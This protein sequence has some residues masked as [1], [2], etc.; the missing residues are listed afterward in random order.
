MMMMLELSATLVSSICSMQI[1]EYCGC[2]VLI[3]AANDN[4]RNGDLRLVGG[5]NNSEGRV[6]IFWNG[7]WGTM[8]SA[9]WNISSYEP[10]LVC[11]QLGLPAE[12]IVAIGNNLWVPRL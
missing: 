7:I 5:A 2:I 11:R 3:N 12:G 10:Q 4:Y 9:K 1:L 8:L 6:E